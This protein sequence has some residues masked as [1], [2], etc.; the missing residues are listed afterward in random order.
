MMPLLPRPILFSL[1]LSASLAS[2]AVAQD[3]NPLLADLTQAQER[4]ARA[5]ARDPA[6]QAV[7]QA[8]Q[9]LIDAAPDAEPRL[10]GWLI[11]HAA[12]TLARL[13]DDG[14]DT[15]AIHGIPLALQRDRAA[16]SADQALA[17]LGRAD[18]LAAAAAAS[19]AAEG[20]GPDAPRARELDQ[21]RAVRIPFF[22]ARA[23]LILAGLATGEPRRA[24][25]Q[26]AHQAIS[27][28]T[29]A[30]GGAEAFRRVTLAA[31]LLLRSDSPADARAAA[32]EIAPLLAPVEPNAAPDASSPAASPAD[33]PGIAVAEAWF[34]LLASAARTDSVD[35]ILPR[36]DEARRAT[37]FTP[38]PGRPD[39]LLIVLAAD[40]AARALL[41]AG[42]AQPD[43]R[44]RRAL[45][46]RAADEEASLMARTDL[47]LAPEAVRAL[48]FEK[49][50]DLAARAPDEA[51][52]PAPMRLAL[53]VRLATRDARGNEAMARLQSIADA[54]GPWA[55]DALW[56]WAVLLSRSSGGRVPAARARQATAV[57]VRLARDHAAHARAP[58]AIAAALAFAQSFALAPGATP[59]DA[60]A[61]REA[62]GIAVASFASIPEIDRWRYE[63]AR[64]LANGVGT[65]RGAAS[66]GAGGAA[67]GGSA[68]ANAAT[69]SELREAIDLLRALKGGPES[70]AD[71]ASLYRGVLR[72]WLDESWRVVA[73]A[74]TSGDEG[75]AK[76]EAG[77]VLPIAREAA[78]WAAGGQSGAQEGG[79]AV[80][81]LPGFRLDL[82]DA[83]VELGDA[84]AA[85]IYQELRAAGWSS[86][87]E[88]G[89]GR[90]LILSG[91]RAGG[92]AVLRDL[93]QRLD[94][95]GSRGGEFWHAWTILLEE[96]ARE[97]RSGT[98][99]AHAR[100]LRGI[101]ADLGGEPWK[102]RI[103]KVTPR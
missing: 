69:R 84:G 88:L 83:M 27:R 20:L 16:N 11:E 73:A 8:R 96:L 9:R 6:R 35:R 12:D 39:P 75:A 41:D 26:A 43:P 74:R 38:E 4:A 28:L 98:I 15:A 47:G 82:A 61:Y 17:L 42:L 22:R 5:D 49:L 101:D 50:A 97:G 7:L 30:A 45:L 13:A 21:D 78:E 81:A 63:R 32:D 92:F 71:A 31:S 25:A 100:R 64:V 51:S 62:L 79:R 87:V 14:S 102:S 86:R 53:A 44:L 23:E 103:A 46:D 56:E 99:T 85:A 3:L 24:R 48:V 40:A 2:R 89:L 29:L 19:L 94:A 34:C 77:E 72:R 10:P 18:R 67:T 37:P 52:L 90:A 70:S 95:P 93:A 1:I 58:E 66:G 36:F 60:A 68:T 57:L 59:E 54:G 55:A 65:A 33:R 91:D 80:E 76:R